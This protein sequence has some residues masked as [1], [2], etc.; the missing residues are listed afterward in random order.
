[1]VSRY[2]FISKKELGEVLRK[3]QNNKSPGSDGFSK[4]LK[5]E[6]EEELAE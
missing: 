4:E 3:M 1:M 2:R 6:E 5:E